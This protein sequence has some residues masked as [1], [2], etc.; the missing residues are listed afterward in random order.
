MIL[1]TGGAALGISLAGW[2]AAAAATA[3]ARKILFFS[4]SSNF[5]HAVIKRKGGQPSFVEK[6]LAELGPKHG[7]QFTFSKDGSLFTPEYL[8]QFDAFFFYTS[9][10][11]LSAGKDAN[12]PMTPAGKAALLDAIKNGKGFI[13]AHSATDTFH[14]GETAETDTNRPR[15]WRYRNPGPQADPYT[16][17][18]GAEFIIHS[19]QQM[20]KMTVADPAFPGM[21]KLGSSFEIMDEWY[22]MTDFSKDLHVLLVQETAGMTGIPYQRPPY[23]ATWARRHGQGRVF[24]TSMGH[25]EDTWTNPAFQ[26]VLFGGIA[27]AAGNADANVAPNIERVTPKCW[28]L[29]PLSAPVASDPAKY[30]PENEPVKSALPQHGF[31]LIELLVVIAIIAILAAMLLP[32]LAR[33]KDQA[34]LS[35]CCNNLKQL[36]V[37]TSL[38]TGDNSECYPYGTS[39]KDATLLDPTA[40][41]ILLLPFLAGKT[42]FGSGV[43]V[44]PCDAKPVNE[45]YKFGIAG[46]YPFQENYRANEHIFR[47]TNDANVSFSGPLKTTRVPAPAQMLL[48]VEKEFDSPEYEMTASYLNEHYLANWNIPGLLN[49]Q[50]GYQFG[51]APGHPAR[52]VNQTVRTSVGLDGHYALLLLS[53]YLGNS[54]PITGFVDLGDVRSPGEGPN[55]TLWTVTFPKLFMREVDTPVGF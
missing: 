15:A 52:G 36:G 13:G 38:Y 1:N 11:L 53:P 47:T 5:E 34:K 31:T 37:A 30:K 23:P 51:P 33:A 3:P 42:N 55:S 39:I 17:M 18:I 4:K 21:A 22:S 40:W 43:F 19:V 8:A 35:Q 54:Q 25:R 2:P 44:C 26:E 20:A 50:N 41:D 24:Y 6:I 10:D 29:P 46:S 27:W 14:T 45:A 7:I 16:R 12:P 9:G 28:E 49:I 48:L 32:A